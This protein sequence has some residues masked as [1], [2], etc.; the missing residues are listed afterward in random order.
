LG[1]KETEQTRFKEHK[2]PVTED[3]WKEAEK[4]KGRDRETEAWYWGLQAEV[5]QEYTYSS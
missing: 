2:R 3:L 4:G 5:P 1:I